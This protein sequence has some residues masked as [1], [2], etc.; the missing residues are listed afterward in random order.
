MQK[1]PRA[2]P[3]PGTI[4]EREQY[5]QAEFRNGSTPHDKRHIQQHH[6]NSLVACIE[7]E[8]IFSKKTRYRGLYISKSLTLVWA[9]FIGVSR[10]PAYITDYECCTG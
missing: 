10:L 7:N 1:L 8:W 2:K 9:T 5:I 6:G 3:D 4:V